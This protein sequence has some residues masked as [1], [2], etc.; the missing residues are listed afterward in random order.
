ME[1]VQTPLSASAVDVGERLATAGYLADAATVFLADRLDPRPRR[2]WGGGDS[3]ALRY[4]AAVETAEC[5]NVAQLT[6]FVGRLL[7]V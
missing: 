4:A 3:A 6:D 5:R 1:D 7:P 2:D